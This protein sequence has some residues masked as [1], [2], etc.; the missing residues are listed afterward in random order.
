MVER[1]VMVLIDFLPGISQG[2]NVQ[3][4]NKYRVASFGSLRFYAKSR[5]L[6]D[7][8]KMMWE[9]LSFNVE[10]A[11]SVYIGIH[12]WR[13]EKLPRNR[14]N[15]GVQT[16]Q[17]F[18]QSGKRL[19]GLRSTIDP[20]IHVSRFD[21]ILDFS[22][23][24][25]KA[26]KHVKGMQK[27]IFGPYVFPC[28][29]CYFQR[30]ESDELVFVGTNKYRRAEI[31]MRLQEKRSVKVISD[32]FYDQV[33]PIISKCS[34]LINI[35]FQEGIYAEWPRILMA[36]RAGK[37][38]FSEPLGAPME[39]GVHYYGLEQEVYTVDGASVFDRINSDIVEKYRFDEFLSQAPLV[40]SV[41]IW[42][43]IKAKIYNVFR[44]AFR[45]RD[46]SEVVNG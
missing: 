45:V 3:K 11:V 39:E 31:I 14:I 34:G 5:P 10:Q 4:I 32:R 36:Y 17:F 41:T 38:I 12:E 21:V 37:L 8:A 7:L 40:K 9:G 6:V 27:V 33:R 26:Y 22:Q 20:C 18:D 25:E 19:W 29:D 28:R 2:V 24:N 13:H 16:E 42:G 1:K 23:F 46:I 35:H 44:S 15:I 30:S 43:E